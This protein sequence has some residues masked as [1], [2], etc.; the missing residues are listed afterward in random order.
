VVGR[1]GALW[2]RLLRITG[3]ARHVP[4][5]GKSTSTDYIYVM[6]FQ[7]GK[8]SHLTKIWNAGWAMKELGWVE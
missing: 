2:N 1:S 6:E 7:D 8:V 4:P 3:R 5:T